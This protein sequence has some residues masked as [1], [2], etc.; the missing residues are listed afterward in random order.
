M[1]TAPVEKTLRPLL[2][3]AALL[4]AIPA[5][6]EPMDLSNPEARWVAV[7]FEVSPQDRP[8]QNQR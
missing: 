1:I 8:G 6:A 2:A 4:L 3:A 7:S 5:A